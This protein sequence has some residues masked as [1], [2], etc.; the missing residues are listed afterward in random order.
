MMNIT[1]TTVS[2][3]KK[4]KGFSSNTGQ[5]KVTV[6]TVS[7]FVHYRPNDRARRETVAKR[8]V[9]RPMFLTNS[10]L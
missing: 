10:K 8:R 2:L 1:R 7:S 9:I 4:T 3:F 5:T 6:P